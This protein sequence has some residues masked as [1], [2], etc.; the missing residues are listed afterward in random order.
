MT[1][2]RGE[3]IAQAKEKFGLLNAKTIV[4]EAK[5]NQKSFVPGDSLCETILEDLVAER[6]AMDTYGQII[7]FIGDNA[8]TTRL[9]PENPLVNEE[10][11]A[12]EPPRILNCMEN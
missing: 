8:A 2:E 1:D 7:Q 12:D 10:E 11:H 9:M 6:I 4:L 5:A 3:C